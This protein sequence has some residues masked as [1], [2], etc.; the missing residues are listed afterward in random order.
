[1]AKKTN[2][3]EPEDQ[4]RPKHRPEGREHQV[5][6]EILERRWRGGPE[7]KP[8]DFE[9]ALEEWKKLPGSIIRPPT[10]V[11]PPPVDE[12]SESKDEGGQTPRNPKGDE[13]K[14]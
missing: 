8:E 13:K 2:P 14:R 1:M 12:P 5:H 10:D 11:T 3:K 6:K 9:R 7:P 4:E